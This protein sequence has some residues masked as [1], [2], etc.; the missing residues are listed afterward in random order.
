MSGGSIQ[1][2]T[3]EE[4]TALLKPRLLRDFQGRLAHA[5]ASWG[6]LGTSLPQE[7]VLLLPAGC[8]EQPG[9]LPR[10]QDDLVQEQPPFHRELQGG[11]HRSEAIP[12]LAHVAPGGG[13]G[14]GYLCQAPPSAQQQPSPGSMALGIFYSWDLREA[15]SHGAAAAA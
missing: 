4:A 15:G 2:R 8:P 6:A 5:R 1:K 13:R 10:G 14:S 9:P 7:R 12:G 3:E 11:R